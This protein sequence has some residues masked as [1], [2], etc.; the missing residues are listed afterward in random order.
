MGVPAA[1]GF[2]D[3]VILVTGGLGGIGMAI[4]QRLVMQGARVYLARRTGSAIPEGAVVPPCSNPRL[5][6]WI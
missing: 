5:I 4:A 2:D 3:R 6:S 1:P